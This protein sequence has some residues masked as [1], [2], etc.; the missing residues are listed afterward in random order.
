MSVLV[1][2]VTLAHGTS[3]TCCRVTC[4]CGGAHVPS[5]YNLRCRV[6]S[7]MV[8]NVGPSGAAVGGE[9]ILRR[10]TG[11]VSLGGTSHL[12]LSTLRDFRSTAPSQN[13]P[14]NGG[15]DGHYFSRGDNNHTFKNVTF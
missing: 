10:D 1:R 2:V 6:S 5:D 13:Q 15:D 3:V 9:D 12:A 11:Y 7:T 8:P 14:D 4:H